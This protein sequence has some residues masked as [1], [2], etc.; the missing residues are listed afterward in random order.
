VSADKGLGIDCIPDQILNNNNPEES[1]TKKL[2]D[3]V[4]LIF[5]MKKI[6]TPFVFARMHL[7]NKLKGETPGLDDLRAIMISSPIIK[8]IEALV[9]Q[10]LQ[11]TLKPLI[12]PA[13]VGFLPKYSTQTQILRLLG[14]VIDY[15]Q[16]AIFNSGSWMILF[17]DFKTAF[18]RV[19]HKLLMEKL[20]KTGVK[21]DT[22]NVVKLLYNSYQFTLPGG[23]PKK[24]NS[25]VAQG[26]LISPIL[27]CWYVNDL[28]EALSEKF[29]ADHTFAYADDIAVLCLGYSE[30]R[31][32]LSITESWAK[33]NNALLNKKKCGLLRIT[34]KETK[35]G[36][37]E[38]DGIPFVKEY[39][40]L[41]VP[42][43]QAFTLKH[44][45]QLVERKL[46]SFTTRI[47]LLPR[48]VIGTRAKLNLWS[49]Y[50]RSHFEYFAPTI[51]LCGKLHKFSSMYTKSLKKSL[52]LPIPTPNEPVLKAISIPSLT[53]LA[54]HHIK[55]NWDQIEK[56]FG[57]S[58]TSLN[59]LAEKL[60][61]QAHNYLALRRARSITHI[62]ENNYS[63]DL[64]AHR[65]YMD[66]CY[67]GLIAGNMLTFRPEIK[68]QNFNDRI[69]RCPHCATPATQ[70]HFLNQCP[71]NTIPR[72]TLLKS[73]PKNY[74]ILHILEGD[75]QSFYRDIRDLTLRIEGN[76]NKKDPFP[77]ELYRNLAQA[78]SSM[79]KTFAAN[80]TALFETTS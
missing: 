7:L 3:L 45:A 80:A 42:L 53:Q 22:L 27:Y 8:L 40:Y 11:S 49:C 9:L 59:Q 37:L 5:R 39:K 79:A 65:D 18:D 6:P 25:G 52:D 78:A 66:R 64:L 26:S 55:K 19:S 50:A 71:I 14:K 61:P 58:P 57:K 20:E 28:V 23:A 34:K 72:E 4:N 10:D 74:K 41:G 77:K 1:I 69:S 54:A 75:F 35:I 70:E 12:C 51:L 68:R 36:Q 29:G 76:Y 17:I 30:I 46:K 21:P 24:V 44:L 43:D 31:E 13:Q 67:L 48:S 38:I 60:D 15:K 56:R 2:T 73:V 16:S 62:E 32:A 33:T 47:H 63:I